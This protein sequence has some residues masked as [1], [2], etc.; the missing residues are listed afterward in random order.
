MR[1]LISFLKIFPN[2]VSDVEELNQFLAGNNY[3]VLQ[4][5]FTD[6]EGL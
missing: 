2:N 1:F 4:E 3:S 6:V 5:I